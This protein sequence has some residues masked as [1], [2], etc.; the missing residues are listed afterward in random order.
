MHW[1]QFLITDL[2]HLPFMHSMLCRKH[3]IFC[4]SV[5][6]FKANAMQKKQKNSK[7]RQKTNL[8]FTDAI[9]FIEV[10]F[11]KQFTSFNKELREK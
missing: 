8:T 1:L 3:N 9:F 5:I 2:Y 11:V 4:N 10:H 6:T 7:Q